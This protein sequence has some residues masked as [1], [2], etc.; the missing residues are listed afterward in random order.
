MS[1][2]LVK[3][4]RAE[5]VDLLRK[6]LLYQIPKSIFA[7][8]DDDHPTH[9]EVRMVFSH[10]QRILQLIHKAGGWVMPPEDRQALL[11]RHEEAACT[12]HGDGTN[13]D[14]SHLAYGDLIAMHRE[15]EG[16]E[17]MTLFREAIEAELRHWNERGE[18]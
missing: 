8:P 7:N 6:N 9:V 13:Y 11:R 17:E 3:K 10:Q 1:K 5:L 15:L 12:A 14:F 16:I 2:G 4:E 18:T